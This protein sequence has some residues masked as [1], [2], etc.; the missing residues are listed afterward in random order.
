MEQRSAY[1]VRRIARAVTRDSLLHVPDTDAGGGYSPP[2]LPPACQWRKDPFH[3]VPADTPPEC[4]GPIFVWIW[5]K[6]YCREHGSALYLTHVR[7][8]PDRDI[9]IRMHTPEGGERS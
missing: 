5:E 2:T 4:A 9:D 7:L 3:D 6:P 1:A 8:Y